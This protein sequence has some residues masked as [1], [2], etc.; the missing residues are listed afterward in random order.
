MRLPPKKTYSLVIFPL[1]SNSSRIPVPAPY[2]WSWPPDFWET[3]APLCVR[4]CKT[5]CTVKSRAV[6]IPY[7]AVNKQAISIS[8]QK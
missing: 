8:I 7:S 3:Y 4:L 6:I 5:L 1:T 2:E